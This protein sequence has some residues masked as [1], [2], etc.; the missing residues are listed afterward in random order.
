MGQARLRTL[1]Q[2]FETLTQGSSTV[3]HYGSQFIS[4]SRYAPDLVADPQDRRLRF[5][6]GLQPMLGL[7]TT[8]Y[9]ST[10]IEA[11]IDHAESLERL[12]HRHRSVR[13]RTDFVTSQGR[14]RGIPSQQMMRQLQTQPIRGPSSSAAPRPRTSICFICHS[15]DHWSRDCP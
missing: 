1:R 7:H 12:Q 3:H 2:S 9:P 5:I 15:P 6:E 10:T 4:L 8:A 13:P 14:G 11:L